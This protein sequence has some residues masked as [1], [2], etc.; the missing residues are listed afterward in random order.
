MAILAENNIISLDPHFLI[1]YNKYARMS[2]FHILDEREDRIMFCYICGTEINEVI[3]CDIVKIG[4]DFF[5]D[6]IV[7]PVLYS[8]KLDVRS[9]RIFD[10]DE[11]KKLSAKKHLCKPEDILS[12]YIDGIEIPEEVYLKLDKTDQDLGCRCPVCEDFI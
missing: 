7:A 9:G 11:F 6:E 3:V 12:K 10:Y 8:D 4:N 5:Y 2:V 1:N